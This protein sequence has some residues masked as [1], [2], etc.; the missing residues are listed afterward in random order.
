MT[1]SY[2]ILHHS[3]IIDN[4]GPTTDGLWHPLL[5]PAASQCS[6]CHGNHIVIMW[7]HHQIT[8]SCIAMYQ[9]CAL[10]LSDLTGVAGVVSTVEYKGGSHIVLVQLCYAYCLYSTH[11][12]YTIST[13]CLVIF[14]C[15]YNNF[16]NC[17]TFSKILFQNNWVTVTASLLCFWKYCFQNLW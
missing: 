3:Q 13:E 15:I 1:S 4:A 2:I 5:I 10:W 16:S 17:G 12:L 7:W 11:P 8:W 6:G 14:E 9:S